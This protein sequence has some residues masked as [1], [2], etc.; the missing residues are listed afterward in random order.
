MLVARDATGLSVDKEGIL[1]VTTDKLLLL[2][3][4][5]AR[6]RVFSVASGVTAVGRTGRWIVVG[7]REGNM[8][9]LDARTGR[10]RRGFVFERV[11]SSQVERLRAGPRE[12]LIAGYASGLVGLWDLRSGIRLDTKK[13]HGPVSH[14]V[15]D[16]QRLHVASE[17][18]SHLVWDLGP[19]HVAYCE[20]LRDV[21]RRVP[22]AWRDGLP[23]LQPA[24]TGHRCASR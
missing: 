12:T 22:V 19:L 6:R 10:P 8:D 15:R 2:D 16:G 7:Y 13:V 20:L 14:L 17:L 11:A 1:V 21:W 24:P 9:L 5:G 4:S 18:G 23:G 3:R